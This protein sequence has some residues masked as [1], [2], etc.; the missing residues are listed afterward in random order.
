[1]TDLQH[2]SLGDIV[3]DNPAAARALDAHGLDYCCHGRDTLGSACAEAGID[4]ATVEGELAELP[5]ADGGKIRD[6]DPPA[7]ADAIVETHHVYLKSELP[8]VDELSAMVVR[9]HGERH[10]ELAEVRRLVVDLREDLEPHLMKEERVL[11]PAIHALWN[12]RTDFPFGSIAA[13]IRMMRF[14]H[15]QAGDLLARLREVTHDYTV[16]EDGCASYRALYE[17]LEAIEYDTHIHI[18]KENHVLFPAVL[19]HVGV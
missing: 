17:R 9:A 10:P 4:P 7:L 12:G 8:I 5:V 3:A 2:R 16:P 14:E 19:E 13:P 18:H 1:M 15:D 6:L 11:F